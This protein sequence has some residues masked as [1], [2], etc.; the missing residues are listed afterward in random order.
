MSPDSAR[1]VWIT[2]AAPGAART[3]TAVA[4]K[5]FEPVVAPL[6]ETR[7]LSAK[8]DLAGVGALAFTSATGVVAFAAACAVRDLPV[9]AVGAA[10][11]AAARAAGFARVESADGDVAALSRLIVGR[12]SL[13]KGAVLHP[14]ARAVGDLAGELAAAGIEARSVALYE[15]LPSATPEGLVS[16]MSDFTAV[17]LFSPSAGR[18]LAALEIPEGT[19]VLCLSRAVAA[20]LAGRKLEVRVAARP[21]EASLLTLLTQVPLI[22]A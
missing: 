1:K 4:A 20:P 8:I 15:T 11:A 17:L 13:I 22:P 2:R 12:R 5:G 14:G 19:R 10:T 6:I 9:F 18:A 7:P 16:R 21:N 3:A